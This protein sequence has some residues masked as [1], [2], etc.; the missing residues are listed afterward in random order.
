LIDNDDAV[1]RL[2]FDEC[3]DRILAVPVF[4]P[5]REIIFSRDRAPG[6]SD[7][8]VLSLANR[9]ETILVTEDVGFGRLVF[10]MA[11]KLPVGIILIALHPMP[12]GERKGYLASCAVEALARADGAFV[13]I[14]PSRIRARRFATEG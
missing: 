12:R 4:A 5:H 1:P 11:S 10:Q 13:T 14:G 3:V 2:L 8:E 6:A 7:A 9:L